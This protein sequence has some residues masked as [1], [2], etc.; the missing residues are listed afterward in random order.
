MSKMGEGAKLA[1]ATKTQIGVAVGAVA[2][3]AAIL[4][5]VNVGRRELPYGCGRRSERNNF[6][7]QRRCRSSECIRR[8]AFV[9]R[10]RRVRTT[11]VRYDY[12]FGYG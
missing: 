9:F 8:N 1:K 2:A 4:A 10:R 3:S 5:V 6:G 7:F 12:G 11:G